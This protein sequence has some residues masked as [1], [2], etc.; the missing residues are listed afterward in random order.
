MQFF[1]SRKNF[2]YFL[3]LFVT[4]SCDKTE[5]SVGPIYKCGINK[6]N[7]IPLPSN[8]IIPLTG[9]KEKYKR[10]LDSNGFKDF[11][12]HLDLL[13]FYDE[14]KKYHLEDKRDLFVQG[15]QKAVKTLQSLL[16][17][18][19]NLN[20]VFSDEA[21]KSHLIYN[22]N[23]T[24][25]GTGNINKKIGMV[26]LG[27]DLYIFIRFESK[28]ILGNDT[29]A[30]AGPLY[31]NKETGQPTIGIVNISRETDFSKRNTLRYFERLILHKFTHILGFCNYHFKNYFHNYIIKE[32]KYGI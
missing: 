7:Q 2:I 18:K 30:S 14:V 28:A 21:L 26:N 15:M 6:S 32:D 23:K 8:N 31:I 19:P 29:L 12:I 10:S 11:N 13:N 1:K 4:I 24:V 5:D 17:V 3:F 25:I 16:K 27:I 22:W 9:D 20:Y